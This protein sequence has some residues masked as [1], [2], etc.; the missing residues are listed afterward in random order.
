[1]GEPDCRSDIDNKRT[2]F[3]S[4]SGEGVS[5]KDISTCLFNQLCHQNGSVL[6]PS[7]KG[8]YSDN[9]PVFQLFGFFLKSFPILNLFFCKIDICFDGIV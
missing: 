7:S 2:D 5:L 8:V 4:E 3:D 1:M 9:F 6:Q